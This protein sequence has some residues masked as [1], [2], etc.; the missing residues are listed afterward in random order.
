MFLTSNESKTKFT[1]NS[2]GLLKD[3]NIL[4]YFDQNYLNLRLEKN[5]VNLLYVK[6][7]IL[8]L[9]NIT[10]S[11][12]NLKKNSSGDSIKNTLL[13]IQKSSQ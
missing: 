6:N 4:E 9:L 10:R 13:L 12:L 8:R 5:S 1:V 11:A 3:K 7:I 2:F